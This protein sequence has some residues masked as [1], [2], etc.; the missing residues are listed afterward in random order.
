MRSTFC[1]NTT[2]ACR[3]LSKRL[4]GL[5]VMIDCR[6]RFQAPRLS[7]ELPPKPCRTTDGVE[8]VPLGRGE[9]DGSHYRRAIGVERLAASTLPSA[10][11]LCRRIAPALARL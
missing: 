6:L 2:L 7:V 3:R 11:A 4:M 10:A 1:W 8:R 5:A 9:P